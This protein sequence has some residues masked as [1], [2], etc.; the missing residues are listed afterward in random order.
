MGFNKYSFLKKGAE[1]MLAE[2]KAERL[3]NENQRK[4]YA[5][6]TAAKLDLEKEVDDLNEEYAEALEYAN[7]YQE[8]YNQLKEGRNADELTK[9]KMQKIEQSIQTTLKSEEEY[10]Q[11][12]DTLTKDIETK[13]IYPKLASLL[14]TEIEVIL[15]SKE[16]V[17]SARSNLL[18]DVQIEKFTKS[19][20]KLIQERYLAGR[21]VDVQSI[22]EEMKQLQ[23]LENTIEDKYSFLSP[24]DIKRLNEL[25]YSSLSNP[26]IPL[27]EQRVRINQELHDIPRQRELLK[28]YQRALNGSDYTIIEL[29]EKNTKKINDL[30]ATIESK[31]NEIT[32]LGKKIATYD[33]DIPQ[34]PDPQYDLLCKLPELNACC[35]ISSTLIWLFMQDILVVLNCRQKAPKTSLS[36]SI[37]KMETKSTSAS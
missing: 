9:E 19:L 32:E 26:F 13:V 17:A 37:T 35:A 18:S 7:E 33:Y 29:Y 34:V 28:D 11:N 4:E 8:Q 24:N 20:V 25:I 31:K 1:A 2:K 10:R 5:R 16:D 14:S 3:E 22:I 15:H 30:K 36:K 27:D 23:E 12:L 6:L 21:S